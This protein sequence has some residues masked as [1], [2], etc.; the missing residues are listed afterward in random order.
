MNWV[1][2]SAAIGTQQWLCRRTG[3]AFSNAA[4]SPHLVPMLKRPITNTDSIPSMATSTMATAA[5]R[6]GACWVLV[7]TGGFG[8]AKGKKIIEAPAMEGPALTDGTGRAQRDR[9]TGFHFE[10]WL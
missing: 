4:D 3:V 1:V 2:S 5:N 8:G 6:D 10:K 9:V 7:E